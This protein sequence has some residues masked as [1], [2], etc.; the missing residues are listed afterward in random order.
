MA[1]VNILLPGSVTAGV[2]EV[3]VDLTFSTGE[4]ATLLFLV[5][6]QLL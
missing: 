1:V 5:P 4:L 6:E 3:A 2:S